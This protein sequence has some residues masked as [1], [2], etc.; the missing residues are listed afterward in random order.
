MSVEIAVNIST[1][2]N[3]ALSGYSEVQWADQC[4]FVTKIE[5]QGFDGIAIPDHLMIGDEHSLECIS[6]SAAFA[7]LTDEIDIYLNTIN[8]N[9]RHGPLLAKIASSIDNISGGRLKLGIGAGWYEAEA[10]AYGYNWPDAPERLYKME[11][12]IIVLKKLWTEDSVNFDGEFYNL[13]GAVCSPHPVQNPHPPVMIGGG[14]EEFTLRIAAKHADIWNYYGD[15]ETMDNK[16]KVLSKHCDIYDRSFEDIKKSWFCRC[17]IRKSQEK[18]ERIQEN[19]NVDDS[20]TVGTP[21]EIL[22]KF[23]PYTRLG[24]DEFVLD[25]IDYPNKR[26]AELFSQEVAPYL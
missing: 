18:L 9:L 7:Q 4:N 10:N 22:E 13:D 8:N 12:S 21:S 15:I 23:K 6:L 16:M 25:F 14:G 5:S 1:D 19:A 20:V 17:L 3:P 26:S 11:E 2:T 24:I